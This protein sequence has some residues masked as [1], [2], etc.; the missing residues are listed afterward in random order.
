MR[1][2]CFE[3]LSS[4]LSFIS[5]GLQ[6]RKRRGK[7]RLA[8]EG[9]QQLFEVCKSIVGDNLDISS[10][11]NKIK[12]EMNLEYEDEEDEKVEIGETVE[13]KSVDT[14]FFEHEKYKNGVLTIGCLGQPNVGKSSLIN[15]IMGR[16][17]VSVSRTPGHT[18]HFQTI[19]LT[20]NVRLCDCPGLVFPS[21]TPKVLQV[22]MGSFP[23][24]QLREPFTTVKFLGKVLV[25]IE[26]IKKI[27]CIVH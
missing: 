2:T 8:A 7:F 5:T 10:W 11:Q 9:S 24:A 13:M 17:V 22:L 6:V 19:F 18:K 3:Y 1:S 21:V 4:Y 26:V 14:S 27:T 20:P 25:I 12:E 23:I 16:K 15:A